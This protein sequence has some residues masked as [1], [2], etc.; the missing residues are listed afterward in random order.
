MFIGD[1]IKNSR[2]TSKLIK[3]Y[4]NLVS[5]K[6]NNWISARRNILDGVVFDSQSRLKLFCNLF[7]VLTNYLENC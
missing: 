5:M 3:S 2:I 4:K 1:T 6:L 7:S